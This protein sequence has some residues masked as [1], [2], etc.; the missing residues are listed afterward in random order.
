MHLDRQQQIAFS[1]ALLP[2]HAIWLVNGFYLSALARISAPL[3]W[4]ADVAHWILL[5]IVALV[6]LYKRTSPGPN[7]YGFANSDLRWTASTLGTAAVF[8]TG[9]LVFAWTRYLSW[10]LFGHPTSIFSFPTMFPE[11]LLGTITWVYCLVTPGIVESIFVIGLPWILYRKA[12]V[13]P[14]RLAFALLVSLVFGAG[15]WGQGPHTAVGAFCFNLVACFWYFRLG[16]LWPVAAGH[17][18]LDLA[19]FS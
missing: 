9:G 19:A 6:F 5:P 16:T 3:F 2:M 7:Q 11:G 10:Q 1:W 4:L 13:T 8:I 17:T 14:S 12:T 18:L 15:H